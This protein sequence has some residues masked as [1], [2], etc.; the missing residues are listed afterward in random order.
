[1]KT[2]SLTDTM[3]EKQR[4]KNKTMKPSESI[5]TLIAAVAIAAA[6]FYATST[7]LNKSEQIECEKWQREASEYREYYLL[8]WQAEQC[9]VHGIEVNAPVKGRSN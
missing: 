3:K 8:E 9:A 5:A 6:L 7:G 2:G 1:M 4:V